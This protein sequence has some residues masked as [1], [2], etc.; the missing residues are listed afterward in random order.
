M[1]AEERR[2]ALGA[3]ASEAGIVDAAFVDVLG[4][5]LFRFAQAV[6]GIEPGLQ[7]HAILDQFLLAGLDGKVALGEGDGFLAR[8]AVLGNQVAGVA[9]EHEIVD[10]T[11]GAAT[12]FDHFRDATKMVAD[13]VAS[14][15]T[16]LDGTIDGGLEIFPTGVPEGLHEIAG[17]LELDAFIWG[18]LAK[19]VKLF[20]EQLNCTGL[21]SD[22]FSFAPGHYAAMALG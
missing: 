22:S 8:I 17:K 12:K 16:G 3:D 14:G 19:S 5:Y 18:S 21:H 15:F 7:A 20:R 10:E 6:A 4:Q 11:L 2:I 9:G 13:R 1:A